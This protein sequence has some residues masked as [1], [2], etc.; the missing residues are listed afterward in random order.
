MDYHINEIVFKLKTF[1]KVKPETN[2]K[3]N[4]KNVKTNSTNT[5]SFSSKL[6]FLSSLNVSPS[7]FIICF[8]K[9]AYR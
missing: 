9:S 6:K 8:A 4:V 7:N 3:Q 2:S 1:L 5:I